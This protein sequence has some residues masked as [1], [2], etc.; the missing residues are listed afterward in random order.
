MAK[1][2]IPTGGLADSAVTSA[3]ITDATIAT[4]DIANDAVTKDKI[5]GINT[6]AFKA[7]RSSAQAIGDETSTVV[8]FDSEIYDTDSAYA[9]G[10]GIFTVPANKGGKYAFFVTGGFNSSQDIDVVNFWLSK[11]DQTAISA[12]AGLAIGLDI[13]HNGTDA[14]NQAM[15]VSGCF[16]LAATDTVR[17]YAW[18]NYGGNRN[19]AQGGRMTFSGFRVADE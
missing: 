4:A 7:V 19:L 9:T 12:T 16:N 18:Q 2:T 17:V 15:Q 3:K 6:P 13:H 1:T 8:L 11:N 5:T 14:S 10:T